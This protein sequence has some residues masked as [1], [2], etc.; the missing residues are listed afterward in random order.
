MHDDG[1]NDCN[2]YFSKNID[3][4]KLPVQGQKSLTNK[5]ASVEVALM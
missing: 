2:L 4:I 3:V 5:K 1:N